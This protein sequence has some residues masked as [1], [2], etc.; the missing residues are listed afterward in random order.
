MLAAIVSI[1]LYPVSAIA[2]SSESAD[3][4][5]S[6]QEVITIA[7]NPSDPDADTANEG[8]GSGNNAGADVPDL[9][10]GGGDTGTG[11]ANDTESAIQPG[12]AF[13][14]SGSGTMVDNATDAE[15]KEFFTVEAADGSVFYLVIDR[16]RGS[17]NVYFLNAVTKN[18]LLSLA[19]E[20]ESALP[21]ILNP[22]AEGEQATPDTPE[23]EYTPEDKEEP[24]KKEG[25]P[26][27]TYIFIILAI[28][29]AAGVGYYLKIYRPKKAA[30]GIDDAYEDET[31]NDIDFSY[32]DE[33]YPDEFDDMFPDADEAED[34]TPDNSAEENEDENQ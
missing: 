3:T 18:D 33:I 23:D 14:P 22:E 2:F 1:F 25:A 8:G 19:D 4:G 27:G 5:S 21:G 9:F 26:A 15:G 17:E 29:I 28:L 11:D 13:T 7:D 16:Q 10:E 34:V 24:A 32:E 6:N 20:K 12:G 30:A 31:E